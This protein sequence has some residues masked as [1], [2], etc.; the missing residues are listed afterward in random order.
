MVLYGLHYSVADVLSTRPQAVSDKA[1][2]PLLHYT[3]LPA[4]AAFHLGI[5]PRMVQLLLENR[6]D[7]NQVFNERSAW[8]HALEA[9]ERLYKDP[10]TL[11]RF[12][13]PVYQVGHLDGAS[14]LLLFA[15]HGAD[16]TACIDGQ[17]RALQVVKVRFESFL[18]GRMDEQATQLVVGYLRH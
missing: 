18:E 17:C 12:S 1:G 14:T 4:G 7:P 13:P 15:K 5:P 11:K 3:C 6:A 10:R 9:H 16:P 2:R 8:Q